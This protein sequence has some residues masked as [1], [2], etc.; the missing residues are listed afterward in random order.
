MNDR[1]CLF[2]QKKL[3]RILAVLVDARLKHEST[4]ADIPTV[5]PTVIH[6][7]HPTAGVLTAVAVSVA[8]S[9]ASPTLTTITPVLVNDLKR[10]SS[11]A[12]FSKQASQLSN[13]H[14]VSVPSTYGR[15]Q[16]FGDLNSMRLVMYQ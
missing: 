2:I 9:P 16:T 7:A 4:A 6:P 3:E 13:I 11:S 10:W 15:K 1:S 14:R 12:H 8:G 5:I